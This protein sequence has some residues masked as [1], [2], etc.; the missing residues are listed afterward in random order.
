MHNWFEMFDLRCEWV[1]YVSLFAASYFMGQVF[2]TSTLA[3]YG[4]RYG[5]V[6]IMR[7]VML[8]SLIL[9][10]ILTFISRSL[11]Y[12]YLIIFIQG[13]IS[14]IRAS[15]SY[16]Y[17]QEISPKNKASFVGCV[18]NII[19]ALTMCWMSLYFRFISKDWIY[20]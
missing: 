18:Y 6:N 4:D 20:S 13:F 11:F 14:N 16:L 7:K 3:S 1:M 9:Q 5:R 10:S 2:G 19:D 8:A 15:L 12:H 17:G